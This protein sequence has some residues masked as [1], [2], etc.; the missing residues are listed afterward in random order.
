[1]TLLALDCDARCTSQSPIEALARARPARTSAV[2]APAEL[3][4]LVI[5]EY[6]SDRLDDTEATDAEDELE[7]PCA[8]SRSCDAAA[9]ASAANVDAASAVAA[10]RSAATDNAWAAAVLEAENE[11]L[12]SAACELHVW[13]P[14]TVTARV[15]ELAALD[16]GARGQPHDSRSSLAA[17]AV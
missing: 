3:E 10:N 5:E 17:E 15:R 9:A 2:I 11:F 16:W 12:T 4:S 7:S 13:I 1:M 14:E 8:A 6:A